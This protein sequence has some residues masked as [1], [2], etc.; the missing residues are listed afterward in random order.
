MIRRSITRTAPGIYYIYCVATGK[1]YIG[2]S[3]NILNHWKSHVASLM[4]NTHDNYRL[5]ADWNH[6][7]VL[8][9]LKQIHIDPRIQNIVKTQ[10]DRNAVLDS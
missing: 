1:Y 7:Q 10:A 6:K 5:Q 8:S 2:S 3:N 4:G 9:L